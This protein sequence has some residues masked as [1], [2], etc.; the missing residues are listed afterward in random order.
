MPLAALPAAAAV[1]RALDLLTAAAEKGAPAT[2]WTV[3]DP[4]ALVLGRSARDPRYDAEA[5]RSEGVEVARRASGGGPLLWD[6]DLLG[7]DVALPP[8]HPL[9]GTDVVHAY[10]WLGEALADGLR[11][12]GAADARV[13]GIDEAREG[14]RD[15]VAEACFGGLSPYEVLVGE[16][17]VVGLS[18]VRRRAGTLLQA[19]IALR[20]DAARL[21]RLMG[22]DRSFA[23]ALGGRAAGLR[24]SGVT[25]GA[26]RVVDAVG[27]AVEERLEDAAVQGD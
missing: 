10:R 19:G 8:G 14:P 22:R 25:A 6:E 11:A 20:F 4:P 13:I 5:C 9:A 17:K 12:V 16:R 2:C 3:A 27:A 15:E 18:Q 23:T 24:E 1:R 7:L 21:A 26:A